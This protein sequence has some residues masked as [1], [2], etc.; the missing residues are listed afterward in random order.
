[1]GDGDKVHFLDAP[2]SQVGLFGDTVKDFARQ[3]S[4]VQKQTEAIKHILPR[5]ESN[6]LPPARPLSARRR[7]HLP[8]ASTPAP[9]P[10]PPKEGV[11]LAVGEQCGPLFRHRPSRTPISPQSD[12]EMGDP[13]MGGIRCLSRH[14]WR[15]LRQMM[16]RNLGDFDICPPTP[17][18]GPGACTF[19]CCPTHSQKEQFSLSLGLSPRVRVLSDALLPRTRSIRSPPPRDRK[20][21]SSSGHCAFYV[22]SPSFPRLPHRR[23]VTCSINPTSTQDGAVISASQPVT[24][25]GPDDAS[26]LRAEIVVLLVE[27]AIKPVPQA[28]I[29]SGFYSP[30]FIVPKKSGL[31][32]S[33]LPFGLALSPHVFTKFTERGIRILNYLDDWLIIAHSRD[34]LCEHRDLVLRHLS[35]LGLEVNWEKSK[36][37]P[38]QG[39]SF[40]RMELDSVN[41]MARLMEERVQSVLSCLNL[42][43]HKT[44]V[45]L[46]VFQKLLGHM[47]ATA[48]GTLLG[49]LH[50]R[51]LQ[52]WLHGQ[53]PRWACHGGTFCPLDQM[54]PRRA[55]VLYATGK[56]LRAPGQDP[57][58]QWHFNCLELLAVFLAL[59]RFRPVLRGKRAS[60]EG[61]HSD[62]RY[63]NH[64]GGL[65]SRRMLQLARHL[66]WNQTWLK[67]LRAVHIPGKL[68]RAA[69]ALTTAKS[70]SVGDLHAFSVNKLCIEFGPADSHVILRPRPDQV[71]NLQVLPPEEADPALQ[72]L[73]P[74]RALR[75]YVN[76]TS[77]FR[78]SKQLF[79]CFGGQQKGNAVSK[80]RLAHWV[81]DA[82][83]A[84]TYV[85]LRAGR[86]LTP[87]QDFTISVKSGNLWEDGSVSACCAIPFGSVRFSQLFPM[88]ISRL[89]FR[90]CPIKQI[91]IEREQKTHLH[92]GRLCFV[93]KDFTI[94]HSFRFASHPPSSSLAAQSHTHFAFAQMTKTWRAIAGP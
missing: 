16:Q 66:L 24:L 58:L 44:A 64:Q 13:E 48:A 84:K 82:I 20:L 2:V 69:D 52:H 79:V 67:S 89:I 22:E 51:P 6:K 85:E 36:L 18:E 45:P 65:R 3:F 93:G 43:R 19:R 91:L 62:G 1:M 77:S 41:M 5:R 61:Q 83:S 78:R 80:Q 4:A 27:D 35:H 53:I 12:P 76:R 50:I 42:F 94:C 40:L 74:V 26:V 14:L 73:C 21:D 60:P 28:K 7:R 17:G 9:P 39:I 57:R 31:G 71:V 15:G 68:N 46:K 86:H 92:G 70:T 47:A 10:P 32:L 63:I 72:L 90:M 59:H 81:V 38:V 49:L 37:S 54:P 56:Q 29:Q 87:S 30:Y 75:I 34:L 8:E 25:V 55:G 11:E 23:Y 33:V 88:G